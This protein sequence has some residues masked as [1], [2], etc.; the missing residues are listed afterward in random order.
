LVLWAQDSEN[1]L[2]E[3]DLLLLSIANIMVEG[4]FKLGLTV[5][6]QIACRDMPG[7]L[8]PTCREQV[9]ALTYKVQNALSDLMGED[10]DMT[11]SFNLLVRPRL[12]Q[13]VFHPNPTFH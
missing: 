8:P 3:E 4:F 5:P 13:P 7:R 2:T 9:K 1:E 11:D 12:Q 6:F 10:E